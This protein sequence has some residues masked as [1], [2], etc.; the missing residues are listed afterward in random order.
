[1]T[2][3]Q[4]IDLGNNESASCGVYPQ[5]DG[6]FLAMTFTQSKSFKTRKGA[7]RWLERKTAPTKLVAE[8]CLYGTRAVGFAALASIPTDGK[9]QIVEVGWKNDAGDPPGSP[10]TRPAMETVTEAIWLAVSEIDARI[11]SRGLVRIFDVAGTRY[12][13][14]PLGN[15][16]SYGSIQGWTPTG[17]E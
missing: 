2:A 8:I 14:L 10:R 15:V 1:M 16:P 17:A 7:E 13:D 5:G 11:G 12:V 3:N 6:S 9:R 4:T